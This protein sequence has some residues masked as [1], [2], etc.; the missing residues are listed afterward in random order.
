M[1]VCAFSTLFLKK[2]KNTVFRVMPILV[3]D[4]KAPMK[5]VFV[6]LNMFLFFVC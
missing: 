6:K 2:N 4:A 3:N 5:S 1:C